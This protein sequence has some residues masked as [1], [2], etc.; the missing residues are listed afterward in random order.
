MYNCVTDNEISSYI[1]YIPGPEK[2]PTFLQSIIT[3][4]RDKVAVVLLQRL[5]YIKECSIAL[6]NLNKE[7]AMLNLSYPAV[8]C[9]NTIDLVAEEGKSSSSSDNIHVSSDTEEGVVE[10]K[11]LDPSFE[12]EAK[13]NANVAVIIK[14][15][16]SIISKLTGFGG[17]ENLKLPINTTKN[18]I[19]ADPTST[20]AIAVHKIIDR[21]LL[22]KS[23]FEEIQCVIDFSAGISKAP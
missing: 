5:Y 20:V 6:L 19:F 23:Y 12:E 10:E 17:E 15:T 9:S 3:N 16:T 14:W 13:A 21:K 11:T 22:D 4:N 8:S 7:A 2:P 18:T 1:F